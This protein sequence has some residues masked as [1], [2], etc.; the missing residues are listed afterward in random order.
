MHIRSSAAVLLGL[1]TLATTPA[2][3][4]Q[5]AVNGPY[6]AT[7]SWDQTLPAGSRFVVLANFNSE[8]VLDRETG[9]VW[10]RTPGPPATTFYVASGTCLFTQIGGRRGWR[11]PAIPEINTLLDST[12]RNAPPVQA[13][14][15]F[16]LPLR[17]ANF[18]TSKAVSSPPTTYYWR[19]A[20][21]YDENNT[22]VTG[23]LVPE[24]DPA[25]Y[26][27]CVRAPGD[28]SDGT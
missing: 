28:P 18:W 2:A 24:D 4:A 17:Y 1:A 8:A 12:V 26:T 25:A 21:A 16:V 11:L 20:Y 27:W 5:T 10:Q 9:L 15:P 13:G 7:P 23:R 19:V 6:Y 3:T 14:H 22:T